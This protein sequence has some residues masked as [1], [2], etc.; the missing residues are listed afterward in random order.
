[1]VTDRL[2]SGLIGEDILNPLNCVIEPAL[3][4]WLFNW[5][6]VA[7]CDIE[8]EFWDEVLSKKKCFIV[9]NSSSDVL[10]KL[11]ILDLDGVTRKVL[12]LMLW[13]TTV[14]WTEVSIELRNPVKW[15][16]KLL[17]RTSSKPLTCTPSISKQQR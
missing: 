7:K 10:E 17:N 14:S 8:L 15:F 12:L 9:F 16:I 5:W 4:D 6:P 1:M 3:F 2:T 13:Q 11:I